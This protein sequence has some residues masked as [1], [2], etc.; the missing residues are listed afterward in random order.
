[1]VMFIALSFA[2]PAAGVA[3][4]GVLLLMAA[5]AVV[6]FAVAAVGS[7]LDARRSIPDWRASHLAACAGT[8]RRS[9]Q[10]WPRFHEGLELMRNPR[11]LSV[12]FVL[13]IFGWLVDIAIIWAYGQDVPP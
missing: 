8:G 10:R 9:A 3:S 12:A 4:G 1:M 13:N 5:G 2:L 6:A 11:L 7:R